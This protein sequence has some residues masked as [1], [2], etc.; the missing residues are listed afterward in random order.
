M[1]GETIYPTSFLTLVRLSLILLLRLLGASHSLQG[2]HLQFFMTLVNIKN[3]NNSF[4]PHGS[5][6][7]YLVVQPIKFKPHTTTYH[8]L[9]CFQGRGPEHVRKEITHPPSFPLLSLPFLT[10]YFSSFPTILPPPVF[11]C[12]SASLPLLSYMNA[13]KRGHRYCSVMP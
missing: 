5:I 12:L 9:L 13:N 6:V 11:P 2:L 3:N 7:L 8:P 10:L 1:P 4:L